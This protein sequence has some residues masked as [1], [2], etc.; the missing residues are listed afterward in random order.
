MAKKGDYVE[1]ERAFAISAPDLPAVL[2]ALWP[3]DGL[4]VVG[5]IAYVI[6]EVSLSS[7][8]HLFG[9]RTNGK[10]KERLKLRHNG[11][12][13]I[14][15]GFGENKTSA[16]GHDKLVEGSTGWMNGP[17]T[18]RAVAALS[19][20]R[21]SFFKD[22][23]K[24]SLEHPGAPGFDI[25][26]DR[27]VPFDPRD[28]KKHGQPILHVEFEGNQIAAQ[29]GVLRSPWFRNGIGRK[30]RLLDD[31]DTKWVLATGYSRGG[32]HLSFADEGTLV[33]YFQRVA[34]TL[35]PGRVLLAPM[36]AKEKKRG[37]P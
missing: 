28:P 14:V 7:T 36:V 11:R 10:F 2:S 33:S 3:L 27:L 4:V 25:G 13:G 16:R 5:R 37:R 20:I 17:S 32:R 6:T 1:V 9:A 35:S 29:G 19:E 18:L 22:R 24:L 15:Q 21:A 12:R 30:L 8:I 23:V 26:F 34:N 31:T